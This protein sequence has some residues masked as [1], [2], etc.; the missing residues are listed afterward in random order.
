[1]KT[2]YVQSTALLMLACLGTA[3]TAGQDRQ[4]DAMGQV[5]SIDGVGEDGFQLQPES[6]SISQCGFDDID[7]AV[8]VVQAG[9]FEE[10]VTL[11][12]S[13]TPAGLSSAFSVN[14]VTPPG[15]SVLTLG[16]L[17]EVGAGAF[18]FSLDGVA[19]EVEES[20]QIAV[21][22]SEEVPGVV[23]IT[24]PSD[25]ALDVTTTPTVTWTEAEQSFEYTLEIAE[26]EGF[27]QI[28]YTATVQGTSHEVADPLDSNTTYHARVLGSNDCGSGEW[29]PSVSFTTESLAGECP[30]GTGVDSLLFED[31]GDGELPAGW[32]TEGSTG[33]V[34]WLVSTDQSF[35]GDFSVFAE[36][37]D[38]VSDQ[39]LS[40]PAIN[41]PD[42]AAALFLTFQNWQSIES[43][44]DGCFDGG[45]L[46]ISTDGGTSWQQVG[47][48]AIQV[49][50][51]D[52]PI[53]N[54][55]GNPLGGSQ[56]WCGDPRDEW[57]RY[58]IDL[59]QWAGEEVSFRFRF[60]TDQSVDRVGWY[61]D[62]VE[63][64]ACTED[65]D[66]IIFQD[67]FEANEK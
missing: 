16:E 23:D 26:D 6:E 39:Q 61:V 46:E 18:E 57:E 67:R 5:P 40:S 35:S 63:V 8:D 14:P 3:V 4:L 51:Y 58:S 29:S 19:G 53:S 12:T 60:G 43:A 17:T 54:D 2:I 47:D 36:N 33:A 41:L 48:D 20:V 50:E 24:A 13:N 9:T 21:S 65:P 66:E 30:T 25:G 10:P 15:S 64:K 55:F 44:A 28:V 56:A 7:L 34:T 22:L 38:S 37:I 32:S 1:M 27:A 49:R 31:F 45:L 52:G 11:S 42:D 59:A 62:A